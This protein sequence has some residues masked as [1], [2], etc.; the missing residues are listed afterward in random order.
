[1][2]STRLRL[3]ALA[4]GTLLLLTAACSADDTGGDSVGGGRDEAVA[5]GLQADEPAADEGGAGS[6]ESAAGGGSAG[7]DLSAAAADRQVVST[8]TVTVDVEELDG[9]V[10]AVEEL[11]AEAGGLIFGEDT[12]LRDGATTHLTV[13]VPPT[14]FR[15]TL[16]AMADLGEVQTQTVVT[17]DVTDRVVDLDSRITTAEASVE[18]LRLLL[19]RAERIVDITSVERELLQRETDLE[20]LRGQ[21]RTLERQVALAT[22]D[23]TL[24]AERTEPPLPEDEDQTGFMDGLRGGTDALVTFAIGL[25]AVVGAL[26]P[27][28]PLLLAGA[29]VLYRT[30]RKPRQPAT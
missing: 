19:D 13:K 12:N 25:S 14:A 24:S 27:W 7:V 26:L 16:S 18:R 29:Y 3:A 15:E 10:Q 9:A 17:D 20:A 5:T 11:V 30:T 2:T 6:G 4:V 21:R 8:A 28:T 22:I 23:V 1:M